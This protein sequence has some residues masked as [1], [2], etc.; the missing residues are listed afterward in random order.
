MT[1]AEKRGGTG[2]KEGDEGEGID[3]G[4]ANCSSDETS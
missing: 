4:V 2:I 3:D 1:D